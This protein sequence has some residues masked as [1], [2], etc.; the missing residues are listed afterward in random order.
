MTLSTRTAK[1]QKLFTEGKVREVKSRSFI[2]EGSEGF[3]HVVTI[4]M[5]RDFGAGFQPR[6]FSCV[7]CKWYERAGTEEPCSHY[8]AALHMLKAEMD[9]FKGFEGE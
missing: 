9:P 3:P 8:F 1:A 5:E 7:P 2:V 4:L 6:R